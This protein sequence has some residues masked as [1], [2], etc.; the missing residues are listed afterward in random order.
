MWF[1]SESFRRLSSIVLSDAFVHS[2]PLLSF[3]ATVFCCFFSSSSD[4][5][6]LSSFRKASVNSACVMAFVFPFVCFVLCVF[7]V[8]GATE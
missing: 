3:A 2:L 1:A 7:V 8:R 4:F 5:T 6:L